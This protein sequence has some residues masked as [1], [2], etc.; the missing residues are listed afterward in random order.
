MKLN[1]LLVISFVMVML[2][3][4]PLSNRAIAQSEPLT[5]A[6]QSSGVQVTW[7]FDQ[8]DLA[9]L[10]LIEWQGMKIPA[11][12]ISLQLPAHESADLALGQ[13]RTVAWRGTFDHTP[14]RIVQRNGALR[15]DL[16]PHDKRTLPDQPAWI[17]REGQMRGTRIV[18]LAITPIFGMN[19]FATSGAVFVDHAQVFEANQ[20]LAN[21]PFGVA[22]PPTNPPASRS[23]WQI[24][25]NQAGIQR[26][27][28]SDLAQA[29]MNLVT[30]APNRLQIWRDGLPIA[31]HEIGT[32]DG[33][34]DSKDELRFYAPPIYD[35][36]NTTASYWLTIEPTSALR[37][38]SRDTT[39]TTAPLR[40]TAWE[41]GTWRNNTLYDS[42]IA[43]LDGD[44]WYAA[45]LRTGAGLPAATMAFTLPTTLPAATGST[46]LT[47]T[48]AAY[49]ANQHRL[50]V[51]LGNLN[52]TLAWNGTGA[53][54]HSL[55]LATTATSGKLTLLV[56]TYADGVQPDAIMFQRAVRLDFGN[57]GA[58]FRGMAG[59][60]RY[61][62]S[63]VASERSLYDVTQAST[64]ILLNLGPGTSPSFQDS[65][66][67]RDYLLVGAGTLA[68]P[69]LKAHQ[70]TNWNQRADV[71]IIAP[72]AFHANL[73]PLVAHRQAQGYSVRLIDPTAIYASW[74]GGD[75][76]P[77]AIRDFLR[78]AAATWNPAPIAV[79][80]VGDGTSDPLNYTGKANLNIIPPFLA[81]V[82]LWLGETACE[83][84]YVQLDGDD[85]LSDGL[86]DLMLGRLP[87]Q[88]ASEVATVVQKII[89][90]E[91]T[92]GGIAWRSRVGFVADNYRSASGIGDPAGDFGYY[93]D[94]LVKLQP[95]GVQIERMYYDPWRKDANGQP[96]NQTWREPDAVTARTKTKAMFNNGAS[97]ITYVGHGNQWMWASTEP[98]ITEP[99]LLSL[100]DPDSFKNADRL[101]I[102]LSL[103]CLTS[104]F[105]EP[106]WSKTSLDERMVVQPNGAIATW[107]ST[108][109]GVAHGHDLLADGF[110]RQLWSQPHQR[111]GD[112]IQAG[113]LKLFTAGGCCQD[114]LRTFAVLGDPLLQPQA[115]QAKQIFV[116]L[117]NR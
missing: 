50:D 35:R 81:H 70:P 97:V 9:T 19:S 64:P 59:T 91:A 56:N 66:S 110:F 111:L 108:G 77:A 115:M 33:T 34:F 53:W 102:V 100:Y 3:V 88:N 73:A 1:V 21:A 25:V 72:S 98:L 84:C 90:Y 23:S 61:K 14:E 94:N 95:R 24:T 2:G 58:W 92:V 101:P 52:T 57:R 8:A 103:T 96:L 13:I 80:L 74:S 78:Y 39:P 43:G 107:G 109:L 47:L 82:D 37:M 20:T 112:S 104:A 4:L 17:L 68:T 106:A 79:L 54:Q 67:N 36:W 5:I 93:S 28:G 40:D 44:H 89:N 46:T 48:G 71:I 7:R 11:R 31:A 87:V 69:T 26:L 27:R 85:P 29:G 32:L 75:V 116:P 86:P 83:T 15:P 76:D 117:I 22:V 18:V 49:T 105:Q 65:L 113:Y 30:L 38:T 55:N 62:L 16:T 45:D 41:H 60:W 114:A 51:M 63:N 10:P 99:F 6:S 42:T 12:L